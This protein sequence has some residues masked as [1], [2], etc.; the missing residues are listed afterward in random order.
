MANAADPQNPEPGV[1]DSLAADQGWRHHCRMRGRAEGA[2]ST[3]RLVTHWPHW[4]HEE[5][6]FRETLILMQRL[7]RATVL[8]ANPARIG[9]HDG[10]LSSSHGS[11]ASSISRQIR[12]Q[13]G[14][15][16]IFV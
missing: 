14:H 6:A 2:I 16:I 4:L 8:A 10:P 12:G 15:S 13:I 9:H 3:A 5:T 11:V 7:P 1:L